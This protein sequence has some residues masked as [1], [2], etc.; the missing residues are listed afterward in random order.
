MFSI[1]YIDCLCLHYC[2]QLT[3]VRC[4]RIKLHTDT[5]V[6]YLYD[7]LPRFVQSDSTSNLKGLL[8]N[9]TYIMIT[10]N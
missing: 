1:I 7:I 9:H 10:M 2:F 4:L 5:T 8:H 3:M 6:D